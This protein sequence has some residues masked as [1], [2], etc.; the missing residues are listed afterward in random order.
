VS[1]VA[2]DWSTKIAAWRNSGL[3]L[4]VW[5]RENAESYHR[6]VYWRKRLQPSDRGETGGFVELSVSAAPIT[7]ECNGILVHIAQGFDPALLA[8][9]LSVLKR[10]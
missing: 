9:V 2:Q 8:E 5:C 3:S 10:D 1:T 6:A 4:P 7:L